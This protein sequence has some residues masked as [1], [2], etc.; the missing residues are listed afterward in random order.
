MVASAVEGDGQPTSQAELCNVTLTFAEGRCEVR[1]GH[2]MIRLGT[3]EHN[4]HAR[5]KTIDV[6]F[7]QSDVPELIDATLRGIYEF[8]EG[9]LRICYGPPDGHRADSFSGQKGTGQYLAEYKRVGS[10]L[11]D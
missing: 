11:E 1:R 2:E 7:Q 3:F 4:D 8:R 6:H 10:S 5:P 9:R